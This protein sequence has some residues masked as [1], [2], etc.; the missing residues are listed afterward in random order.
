MP[1]FYYL[2]RMFLTV[3]TFIFMT[4]N[5]TLYSTFIFSTDYI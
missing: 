4:V 3:N 5:I 2:T 1:S